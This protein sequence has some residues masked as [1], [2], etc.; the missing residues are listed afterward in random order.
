MD[1]MSLSN[2]KPVSRVKLRRK[3]HDSNPRRSQVELTISWP[4]LFKILAMA[5]LVALGIVLAR[6]ASLVFLAVLLG[7]SLSQVVQFFTKRGWPRWSGIS[8]AVALILILVGLFVSLLAPAVASQGSAFIAHLPEVQKELVNQLPSAGPLRDTVNQLLQSA[9][10]SNPEQLMKGFMA[11]G[12]MVIK[13]LSEFLIVLVIGVYFLIDG[14]QI[15]RWI[16]A[17]LPRRHRAKIR[18]AAPQIAS[19]VSRFVTGQF[20][21]SALCG[22]Y[23]FL[24]L[25]LFDVPNAAL[26]ATLAAI[27]DILP[28]I[29]FFVFAIPAIGLA[30][31][32]SPLSAA[33][34]GGLYGAY[35]LLETYVIVPK[36]YGNQLKLSTLTVLLACMAGWLLAGVIGAI[37]ILPLVA[38]YPVAENLWLKPHL[39]PD[40]VPKHKEIEKEAHP[41]S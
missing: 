10:F 15:Y 24:V 3:H 23:A 5:G 28:V 9:S 40:T 35:H 21:T 20:V 29:G 6:L 33:A 7:V 12:T 19:I 14:E 34:V 22:I 27:F 4:V 26:L 31:T 17:F 18:V 41:G 13:G 16:V 25:Y 11:C 1:A 36:V 37:A 8:V 30:Y 38:A 32:V 2:P 39:E